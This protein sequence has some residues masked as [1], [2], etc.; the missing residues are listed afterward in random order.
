MAD[1][2]FQTMF[3]QEFIRGFEQRQSVLRDTVTTEVQVKGQQVT[4]LIADSG[5]A[6]AVTRGTNGRIPG[7]PDNLT[8]VTATLQEWH[9]KPERTGFNLFASQ[10]DGR[11]IMQETAMAVMNRKIDQTIITEL[12]T[13]TNDTGAAAVA[14]L[15]L[16]AKAR[17]ILG[18][19]DVPIT[20]GMVSVL[21]SPAAE[22]YLLQT[23]EFTNAEYVNK[24]PLDGAA[25]GVSGLGDQGAGYYKWMSMNWIVHPNLPGKGTNAE[26]MFMYHRSAIGHAAPS[27]L[28]QTYA[29]YNEEDDY[30]YARCTA[31]MAGKLLQNSGVVVI[32]HDG[33]AFAAS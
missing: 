8:Q 29:D 17:A 4:F 22:A 5:G 21:I 32:N 27:D 24:K 9:D 25:P 12:A 20:D 10:G 28:I 30:S 14:S 13:A 16:F 1:T 19:N 7:R 31:Y 23:K 6:E 11:R 18:N 26:K 33:S 2:A 3:K 15:Q